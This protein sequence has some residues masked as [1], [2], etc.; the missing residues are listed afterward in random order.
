MNWD[1][2]LQASKLSPMQT[3]PQAML[4]GKTDILTAI[5]GV[6]KSSSI[7]ILF[8]EVQSAAAD[9]DFGGDVIR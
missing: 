2:S 5:S 8:S 6:I 4:I 9:Q 3:D 1:Y 7:S